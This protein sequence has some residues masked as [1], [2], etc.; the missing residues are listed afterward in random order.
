MQSCRLYSLHDCTTYCTVCN[1]CVSSSVTV[2]RWFL[3]IAFIC[4]CQKNC[5]PLYWW[6]GL[7]IGSPNPLPP[8][9]C[10]FL[11]LPKFIT[12]TSCS[13]ITVG[14]FEIYYYALLT[15]KKANELLLKLNLIILLSWHVSSLLIQQ[16]KPG[17]GSGTPGFPFKG[18]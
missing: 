9:P 17:Y 2:I 18:H 13:L 14:K 15:W 1:A 16:A 8:P 3:G 12:F 11:F 4:M 5:T 10:S 7:F 6:C